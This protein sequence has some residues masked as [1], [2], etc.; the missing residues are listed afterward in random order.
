M[1][2]IEMILPPL[3]F[4]GREKR[5]I[6]IEKTKLKA[7][8]I[9]LEFFTPVKKN[10][11]NFIFKSLNFSEDANDIYQD[12]VLRALKYFK[13]FDKTKPFKPW[14]FAIANNEIKKHFKKSILLYSE[15]NI[16]ELCENLSDEADRD[17]VKAI[18]IVA[19]NLKPQDRQMFFL[20]YD[21][22]FSIA[23]ISGITGIKTGY[24]KVILSNARKEI[25]KLLEVQN[26]K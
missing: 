22:G 9:F 24:I 26:E 4:A 8:D 2:E 3:L 1:K 17:L 14:L 7:N 16:E 20:F 10:L 23:E 12:T 6:S 15:K 5:E 19:E 21:N 25:K 18:Y 13:K 11:Y